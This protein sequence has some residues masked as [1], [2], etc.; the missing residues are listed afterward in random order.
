MADIVVKSIWKKYGDVAAVKGVSFDVRDGEIL[1]ILG[2][3]GAGKT[4]TLK[5]I[6]G[7][8]PLSGGE[9]YIDGRLVNTVPTKKR[10]VAM[11]FETYALY[12]HL[13]V[14]GNLAFPLRAPGRKL[15][16][17]EIDQRVLWAAELLRIPEL[18]DR[19]PREL[20]SGQKQRVSVGRALVRKPAVYLMDE[21]ISHLD[22]KLRHSMRAELKK[23]MEETLHT[24]TIYVTHDY[25][26]VMALAN[27][28]IVLDKGEMQQI[29][30][31]DD[32]FNR[33]ANQFV[34][35]VVGSPPINF[36]DCH[37][38][39]NGG[40]L[41]FD[42]DDGSF[43]VAAPD[44]LKSALTARPDGAVTLGVRPIDISFAREASEG[45]SI[46]G[47][48]YIF[49]PL[50]SSGILTVTV[51]KKRVQI[52]TGYSVPVG[53]GDRVWVAFDAEK[54]HVFDSTTTRSILG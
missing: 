24:S 54:L 18:L 20:S 10:D 49:E 25:T 22:A 43:H 36:L 13:N 7:V 8:V 41:Y 50:G 14:R 45:Y 4:S 33:P 32:I 11:I 5:V 27:K 1:A 39:S 28:A 34:A 16:E 51:G 30:T 6:A 21:P 52:T 31:P 53:I 35:H 46:P 23:I 15:T 47:E 9:I 38:V 26:E 19:M 29:G 40:A 2:P 12:P 3:S 44:R 37:V 17:S 48:V 42:A